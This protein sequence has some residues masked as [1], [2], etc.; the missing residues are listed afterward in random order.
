[1]SLDLVRELGARDH[2][3]AVLVTLRPDGTPSTSVVNAGVLPHPVTGRD[4]VA[5]VA[6]GA[7]AKLANLRANPLVSL[8]FR[9]G[10]EWVAVHGDAELAGPDDDLPGLAG[11]RLRALLRDIYAS[12]GGRHPDLDVYDDVMVRER[13]TAV[14][15]EPVRFATNPPGTDHEEHP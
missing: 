6:R 1:M 10:W 5:F 7:T 8:V 2:H 9:A 11:D 12:A 3:L 4:V 14:L 15:V 13:R